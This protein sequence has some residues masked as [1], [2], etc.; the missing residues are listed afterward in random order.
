MSEAATMPPPAQLGHEF[1]PQ[2]PPVH[3]QKNIE[4][5]MAEKD[6]VLDKAG[7]GFLAGLQELTDAPSG[8]QVNN[9]GRSNTQK[10]E[11]EPAK[12]KPEKKAAKTAEDINKAPEQGVAQELSADPMEALEQLKGTEDAPESKETAKEETK[13][14]EQKT[15]PTDPKERE[16]YKWG[17]LKAKAEEYDKKREEWTAKEQ[18][19]QKQITEREERLK[20]LQEQEKRAAELE[21][22]IEEYRVKVAKADI[23]EDPEYQENFVKPYE[24]TMGF[25]KQAADAYQL[26]WPALVQIM[27]A[28]KGDVERNKA[29]AALIADGEFPVDS[30][31]QSQMAAAMMDVDKLRK[32]DQQLKANSVQAWEAMQ[33]EKESKTKAEQE[34]STTQRREDSRAAFRRMQKSIAEMK[35]ANEEEW[36]NDLAMAEHPPALRAAQAYALRAL[37]MVIQNQ[38]AALSAKDAEIARLNGIIKARSNGGPKMEPGSSGATNGSHLSE[39]KR[40]FGERLASA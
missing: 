25:L 4:K 16:K 30:V 7:K 8:D 26:N 13:V 12:A 33:L 31:T 24:E 3:I 29:F 2:Q 36:V 28:S 21:K 18:D 11:K 14:E 9:D 22:K 39:D 17:E 6:A 34:K 20:S 15:E 1:Q 10:V 19:W 5:A 32:Y 40:S 37:P 23:L 38:K 35:D 27:E